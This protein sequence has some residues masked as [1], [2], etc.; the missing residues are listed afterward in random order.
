[1]CLI[2]FPCRESLDANRNYLLSGGYNTIA[3]TPRA[4]KKEKN[5]AVALSRPLGESS[6]NLSR[7][8]T[9]KKEKMEPLRVESLAALSVSDCFS[10]SEYCEFTRSR[11][12]LGEFFFLRVKWWPP[13]ETSPLLPTF[14]NGAVNRPRRRLPGSPYLQSP[15]CP[16]PSRLSPIQRV[17][18]SP[19]LSGFS[20]SSATG[21]L[22]GSEAVLMRGVHG[23]VCAHLPFPHVALADSNGNGDVVERLPRRVSNQRGA[24]SLSPRV[25]GDDWR[26]ATSLQRVHQRSR[27]AGA[28]VAWSLSTLASGRR[29]PDM[30][31]KGSQRAEREASSVGDA[32][33]GNSPHYASSALRA[34]KRFFKKIYST[35]TLPG[36]KASTPPAEKTPNNNFRV[37]AHFFDAA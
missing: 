5:L 36:K 29:D 3:V 30:K 34:T 20:S 18:L 37:F 22:Q 7:L 28:D 25:S 1:M 27:S 4:R 16:P 11:E 14:L 33:N 8:P 10:S 2:L 21:S 35:A 23:A 19:P 17:C 24:P 9:E 6:P 31:I 32:T 15:S 12:D 13:L 26:L